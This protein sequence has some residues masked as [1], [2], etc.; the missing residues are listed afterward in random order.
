MSHKTI[1]STFI[2]LFLSFLEETVPAKAEAINT[3]ESARTAY[4]TALTHFQRREYRE[5]LATAENA[6]RTN[7]TNPDLFELAGHAC[8]ALHDS[9]RAMRAYTKAIQF[10]SRSFHVY[11]NRGCLY[12]QRRDWDHALEDYCKAIA[13]DPDKPEAYYGRAEAYCGQ[14]RYAKALEDYEASYKRG[15]GSLAIYSLARLLATCPNASIRDGRK[16]LEYAR[17][18]CQLTDLNE[19]YSLDVLSMALAEVGQWEEAVR[20]AEQALK[21]AE[22]RQDVNGGF[23][24]GIRMRLELYKLHE[25]YRKMPLKHPSNW[26]PSSA[27]EALLYGVSKMEAGN[28]NGAREDL[29][30]AIEM[31]PHLCFAH[32]ALGCA[33]SRLYDTDN[34]IRHFLQCLEMDNKNVEGLSDLAVAYCISCNYQDA[35]SDANRALSMNARNFVA[36]LSHAWALG[37][38]G[39]GDQSLKEL[40]QLSR[41]Y[42]AHEQINLVRGV[43]YLNQ[44]RFDDAV[45]EFTKVIQRNSRYALA[46]SERAIALSAV[47][48]FQ[49]AQADLEDCIRLA[50]LL[51]G[52]TEDRMKTMKEKK[53]HTL[54]NPGKHR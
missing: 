48:K 52:K 41:E 32:Y 45:E 17:K 28:Y 53:T 47:G 14:C 19:P 44:G 43:C 50:P 46:Y 23:C 51:R 30:K 33:M 9:D 29:Q 25:P 38:L 22:E 3:S 15:Y 40:D 13:V 35:L 10:S 21:L 27:V 18:L 1:L 26:S 34:A 36:R 42:P 4:A 16:S 31:N 7:P 11:N 39:K 6:M 20:R 24:I 54:D 37:G 2:L 8:I 12:S 5:A 49:K